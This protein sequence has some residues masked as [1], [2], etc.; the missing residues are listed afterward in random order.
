MGPPSWRCGGCWRVGVRAA[1]LRVGSGPRR[2]NRS[3][4]RTTCAAVVGTLQGLLR[5]GG[6]GCCGGHVVRTVQLLGNRAAVVAT[7]GGVGLASAQRGVAAS[8][9]C[10]GRCRGCCEWAD[11][12]PG[13]GPAVTTPAASGQLRGGAELSPWRELSTIW[14]GGSRA[15]ARKSQHHRMSPEARAALPTVLHRKE[16]LAAGVTEDEIRTARRTGAWTR[17][18]RGAYCASDA[19]PSEKELVHQLRAVAIASR[20][21][22]LVLSHVSAAAVHHLPIWGTDL[23]VVHL[24]RLSASGGRTGPGRRVHAI[25]LRPAEVV[26]HGGVRVTSVA[27][28]LIDVGCTAGFATTVIA[29]DAALHRAAVD[30]R[31]VGRCAR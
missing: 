16:L 26:V 24:T 8:R 7:R 11:G 25:E 17:L 6:R 12:A 10:C 4:D 31:G 9:R 5:A 21:P 30:P 19:M 15:A 27:R 23:S 2:D 1:G 14:R 20:S 13:P 28:T 22:H 3:C 18:H 29:A